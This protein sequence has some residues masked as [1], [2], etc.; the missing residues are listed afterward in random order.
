MDSPARSDPPGPPQPPHP[1]RPGQLLDAVRRALRSR[2]YSRSTEKAYV[3]WIRQFIVFNG[4]RHPRELGE[5]EVSRFLT[6]LAVDRNVSPST[7]N[8][9]LS[10]LLFLYRRV[11]QREV[12]WLSEV[13]RAKRPQR[14]PVVLSRSEVACLLTQLEGT[15]ELVARLLYGS[16][17][18]LMETLRLR[19]KDVDPE[20]NRLFVRCGKGGKDRWSVFPDSLRPAYHAHM[21]RVARLHR[22]DLQ[23]GAGRVGLPGALARKYPNAGREWA[24]QYVF[25]ASRRW[26][27]GH[28][29]E[30]R[31]HHY[32]PSTVQR[33]IK[34]ALRR[35][36]IAKPASCHT[37][38]HSFA[39]HL[40][41]DGYDI[42]TVQELLGH[43]DVSTTMIY[44]HVLDLGP[45]GVRSPADR[46]QDAMRIPD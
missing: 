42:R 27:D 38:R 46:L 3:Y 23:Q 24:W 26:V 9:A 29:G 10:A 25:P 2:R 45:H 39:T 13:V 44:T 33:A 4:R 28:S 5:E 16:G 15:P 8:Q 19:V 6:S 32:H 1:R 36:R 7:Q 37:L 40:I 34:S 11:L 14:L 21:R 43:S 22:V 20:R 30:A 17:L 12:A 18:R 31:R 35:A 41:E